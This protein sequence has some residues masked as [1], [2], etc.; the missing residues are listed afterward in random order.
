[1]TKPF[2]YSVLRYRPSYLLEE[3]INVGLLFVF[4]EEEEVIFLFPSKLARITQF[5]SAAD[6]SI[7]RKYLYAFRTKAKKATIEPSIFNNFIPKDAN[8]FYLSEPK[9]GT[10]ILKEEILTYYENLYFKSYYENEMTRKDDAYLKRTFETKLKAFAP[11]KQHFFKRNITVKN[12]ITAT[13]FEY[14]WQNGQTNL[15]KTIGLD[16]ASS[17]NIQK[18]AFRWFGE[19]SELNNNL[20]QTNID[21]IVS[22]P[23]S[24]TLYKAYDKALLILDNIKTQHQIKEEEELS[25]YLEYAVGTVREL[26]PL[27]MS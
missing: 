21:I 7:L 1:M 18:K 13:R 19:L 27:I 9:K 15:V 23:T 17:T 16:L 8:S 3:Q 25:E 24:K 12:T 5:Y 20:Q 10:Y 22:R 6:L 11:K 4:P 2:L 14:A 26:E